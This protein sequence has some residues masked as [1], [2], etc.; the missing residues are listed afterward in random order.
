MTIVRYADMRVHRDGDFPGV[1]EAMIRDRTGWDVAI[2]APP[3]LDIVTP[4][5]AAEL[6][7]LR[8]FR[9]T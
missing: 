8:K 5:T 2:A 7:A 3:E 4:P 6:T 1:T 9:A